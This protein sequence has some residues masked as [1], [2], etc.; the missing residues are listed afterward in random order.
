MHYFFLQV[1][2]ARCQDPVRVQHRLRGAAGRPGGPAEGPDGDVSTA[3]ILQLAP[4][5][6]TQLHSVLCKY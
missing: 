5:P 6:T 1:V 3:E 2:P 4:P